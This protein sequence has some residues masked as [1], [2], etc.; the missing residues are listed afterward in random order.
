MADKVIHE[1]KF[2]ETDDGYRVEIKGDKEQLKKMFEKGRGFGPMGFFAHKMRHAS[3][4]HGPWGHKRGF[5][6]PWAWDWH[7]EEEHEHERTS[8]QPPKMT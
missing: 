5:G 6:P 1:V 8:E 4:G 2:I 3:W 7:D